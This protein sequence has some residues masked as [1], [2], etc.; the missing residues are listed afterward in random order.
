MHTPPLPGSRASTSSGTLRGL[1]QTARALECEK[2]TGAA[3]TSSASCIV[4]GDT[5]DRSTSM[6]SRCISRTTSRPKSVRPPAAFWSVAES[7]QPTLALWVRVMYR[8]PSA[9]SMRSTPSDPAIGVAAFGA[10]Q[11]G[12]PAGGEDP[13]DVGGGQR[14]LQGLGVRRDHPAG[15]VDLLEHR[16]DGGVPGDRGR[17]EDRPELGADAAGLQPRQ[18]G[19]DARDRLGQV[20][21][22]PA[23]A[24]PTAGRCARRSAGTVAAGPGPQSLAHSSRQP[25]GKAEVGKGARQA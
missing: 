1:S 25:R 14:E 21:A 16:G 13:L 24:A 5:C 12:H 2:I 10:E 23:R 9:Y 19:V 20:D 6:P 11:R 8:T 15:Q 4:S 7:A 3:A 22:R 18:V 17:H